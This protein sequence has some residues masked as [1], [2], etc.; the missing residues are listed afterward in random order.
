MTLHFQ[1]QYPNSPLF[2]ILPR[3]VMIERKKIPLLM[4]IELLLGCENARAPPFLLGVDYQGNPLMV[5]LV[6][7]PKRTTREEQ[8][9]I[10]LILSITSCWAAKGISFMTDN[11]ESPDSVNPE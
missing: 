8:D 3:L 9:G 11:K 4:G 10:V 5:S 7:A 6:I 1:I 2:M